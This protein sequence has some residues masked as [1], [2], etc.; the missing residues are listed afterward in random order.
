M[1]NTKQS[2]D[3]GQLF[4]HF[5]LFPIILKESL[6]LTWTSGQ[7][8]FSSLRTSLVSSGVG[9][10]ALYCCRKRTYLTMLGICCHRPENLVKIRKLSYLTGLLSLPWEWHLQLSDIPEYPWRCLPLELTMHQVVW[11]SILKYFARPKCGAWRIVDDKD[12]KYSLTETHLFWMTWSIVNL[13][14]GLVFRHP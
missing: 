12:E 2:P 6:L 9:G 8:S 11:V 7:S 1:L 14:S 10:T 3:L 5:T 13:S 4:Y